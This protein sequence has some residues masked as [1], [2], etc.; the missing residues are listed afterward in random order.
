MILK[1]NITHFTI[2][3][4]L[5]LAINMRATNP[6]IDQQ[7]LSKKA[8][9]ERLFAIGSIQYGTFVL[10][11]G[12]T[13]SDYF[14]LRRIISYPDLLQNVAHLF[15]QNIG[16][17]EYDLL[18][19][20]P[21]AAVPLTASIATIYQKP[22][23]MT[24]QWVKN[25]GN[26]RLIEGVYKKGDKVLVIEDV[27]TTGSSILETVKVLKQEG[28][29]VN[30]VIVFLDREQGGRQQ[31]AKHGIQL[32]AVLTRSEILDVLHQSGNID[33]AICRI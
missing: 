17:L 21:S 3:I 9:I 4:L 27:I 19:G 28:L 12:I 32:H 20:V 30:D 2:S 7:F 6:A 18:C 24:R 29:K 1:I 26:K 11:S 15:W 22:M 31:L 14:D 16:N 25:H 5:F 33:Q 10:K 13:S 8:L 23:I